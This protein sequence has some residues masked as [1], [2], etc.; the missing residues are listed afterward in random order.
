MKN[1]SNIDYYKNLNIS[2]TQ[3]QFD[4]IEPTIAHLFRFATPAL[5]GLSYGTAFCKELLE[6]NI[7]CDEH[8]VIVEVGA[9]LGDFAHDFLVELHRKQKQRPYIIID[10]CCSLQEKQK[11][12]LKDFPNVFFYLGDA[13][14]L[15]FKDKELE[16]LIIS[17]E[18]IADFDAVEF[19]QEEWNN[20]EEPNVKFLS[21]KISPIK[22][23]IL[24]NSGAIDF[25]KEL[26]RVLPDC[27]AVILIEHGCT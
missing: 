11:A 25:I 9:G 5:H 8:K 15:P 21:Q 14:N 27:G 3:E 10:I 7:L 19:S 6:R 26:N 2:D 23:P 4:L 1:Y 22:E 24:F 17:N 13:R 20:L 16:G 12:K 18:V